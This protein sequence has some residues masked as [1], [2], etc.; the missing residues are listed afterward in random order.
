MRTEDPMTGS[1][2][3][4]LTR[5]GLLGAFAAGAAIATPGYAHAF[6]FLRRNSADAR[7]L[8]MY[9]ERTGERIDTIYWVQGEYI[10][11]AL[12]EITYFMRDWRDDDMKAINPR[13]LDFLAAVHNLVEAD[14]PYMLLSGFRSQRTNRMLASRSGNVATNSLHLVGEAADIRLRS[15]SVNQVAR[16]AEACNIG[17]VGRYSRSNFVHLDCGNVRSWGA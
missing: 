11:E 3:T 14:E 1:T 5:R 4:R 15:R 7:R 16:A 13:T 2:S 8:R 6:S 12:Q 10:P 17:G 9:S